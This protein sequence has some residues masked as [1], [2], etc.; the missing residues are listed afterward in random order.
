[1]QMVKRLTDENFR[2]ETGNGFSLVAFIASWCPPCKRQAPV[3]DELDA[4][5]GKLI[6]LG[7]LDTDENPETSKEFSIMSIPTL[8]LLKDGKKVEQLTGFHSKAE[9]TDML[10]KYID[11]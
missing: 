10:G 3:I 8:I 6:T 7:K 9:L 4:E 5:V 1:M 11:R 2:Q